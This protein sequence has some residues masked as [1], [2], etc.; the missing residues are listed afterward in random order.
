VSQWAA[1]T[2]VTRIW[3]V[4]VTEPLRQQRF[5]ASARLKTLLY[6]SVNEASPA[7]C[8]V[9]TRENESA[10]GLLEIAQV[11]RPHARPQRTPRA[12]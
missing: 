2:R 10:T 9:C 7:V 11:L 6:R 5:H 1:R 8:P 12:L 3:Q 4:V